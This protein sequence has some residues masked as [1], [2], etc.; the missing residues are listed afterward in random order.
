M[1]PHNGCRSSMNPRRATPATTS[2]RRR[3]SVSGS[4][5]TWPAYEV[6]EITDEP[7]EQGP[8]GA[9]HAAEDFRA[10]P[11]FEC[12]G[13]VMTPTTHLRNA[14]TGSRIVVRFNGRPSPMAPIPL[15]H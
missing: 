7:Y 4:G 12:E 6:P 11:L 14:L 9:G 2:S 5:R 13:H 1:T 15:P 8:F 10:D 3:S